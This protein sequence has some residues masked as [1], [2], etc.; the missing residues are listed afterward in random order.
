MKLLKIL[1]LLVFAQIA[2][3]APY[4]YEVR[5]S[6]S[7]VIHIVTLS[8][9]DYE[10]K[11]VKAHNQVFGRETVRQIAEREN[12][13]IAINS[14]FFEIG[15]SQDGMPSRNMIVEGKIFS[16]LPS[17]QDNLILSKGELSIEAHALGMS[18]T[19]GNQEIHINKYNKFAENDDVV[20]YTDTFGNA[21][22]TD[23]NSRR[24]AAFN[25]DYKLIKLYDHGNIDIPRGGYVLSFPK[26]QNPEGD[27]LRLGNDSFLLVDKEV[28]IVTGIPMLVSGGVINPKISKQESAFYQK[29][30]SRT[31]LGL[32]KSG[33]VVLIVAE[34]AYKKDLNDVT[35]DEL[36]EVI[37]NNSN[38]IIAKY[39]KQ[40]KELTLD[41]LK[42]VVKTAY[43]NADVSIGLTMT[44]LAN[45]MLG[46]GCDSAINL[47]G[48]GSSTLWIEGKIAG[49]TVG[50][51][52]EGIGK[53]VERPVSDAI[54]FKKK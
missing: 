37:Q 47:D 4:K 3:A 50:D 18:A 35:M 45:L 8:P 26:L 31:A 42:E 54:I 53:V 51:E 12:A 30:H 41:E 46:L 14:G 28:S 13:D 27:K 17:M 43:T 40:P 49:Q 23:Y 36:R 52:D 15:G 2:Y 16:L 33:E 11:F 6:D 20:L 22:L 39:K 32:K 48:G 24:E 44:E 5:K 9:K 19:L 34:Y 7:H 10:V 38:A 29:P 25:K 1:A 21:T